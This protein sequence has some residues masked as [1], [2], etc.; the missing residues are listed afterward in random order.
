MKLYSV[1]TLFIVLLFCQ[2]SFAQENQNALILK[3]ILQRYY[4]NEK[5]V[6]KGR[7]Q[8]LY[9]Y[10]SQANNNEEIFEAIKDRKLPNDFLKE[11]RS[12][13]KTDLADRDWSKELEIIFEADKTSLKGKVSAC[14][15]LDKYH[16]VSKRLNLNNQRLMIISKP[17]YYSKSNIAL[18][19]VVFYRS[20]E[21]NKGA[22]LLLEKVDGNWTIKEYLNPWET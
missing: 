18:V 21:H 3:T 13:V 19:K 20:I 2:F 12:N 6:Y 8:L 9:L 17:L 4:Q 11:M 16:E 15:D 10:C 14:L 7:S 22:I 1:K 5:P